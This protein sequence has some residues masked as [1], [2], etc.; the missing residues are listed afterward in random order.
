MPFQR[1]FFGNTFYNKKTNALDFR[2]LNLFPEAD[3]NYDAKAIRIVSENFDTYMQ[4]LVEYKAYIKNIT[5]EGH[6][7]S[8][9]MEEDNVL[10]SKSRALVV[11]YFVKR[12]SIVKQYYMK[13]YIQTKSF[14][15]QKRVIVNGIEDKTASR[16]IEINFELQT[17]KILNTLREMTDD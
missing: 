14:G 10:L 11:S 13:E 12:L 5:I 3:A 2:E 15:S 9:G 6:T 17:S 7:D 8:S 4:I 1:K 16:R